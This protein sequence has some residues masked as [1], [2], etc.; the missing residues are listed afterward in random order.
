MIRRALTRARAA[1]AALLL[2]ALAVL[3]ALAMGAALD[4]A[5]ADAAERTA[6]TSYNDGWADG[7]ADL[8]GDDNRDGRIDEDESGWDCRTMGNRTCGTDT[9]H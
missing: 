9:R 1:A 4:K 3:A 7:Q 6:V 2:L 8:T 5:A